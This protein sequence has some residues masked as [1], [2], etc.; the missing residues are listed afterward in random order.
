VSTDERGKLALELMRDE[1]VKLKVYR[2]SLGIETIGVGRNLRDK[3][4]TQD[5]ALF[6]LENDLD[7]CIHDLSVF[8][9]FVAL[10]PVRQRVVV[11]MRFNLGPSRLRSFTRTL[12]AVARGD[13]EAAATG[14][15]KSKWA[16]QVGQ[17]AVRLAAMMRTGKDA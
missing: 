4:I 12:A 17:R 1:G 6:L 3:G 9:W 16:K 8:P 5:E 7:E 10:D 11:D 15:L 2:D 14:M 13:Y